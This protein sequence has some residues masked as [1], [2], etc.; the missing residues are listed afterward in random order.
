MTENNMSRNLSINAYFRGLAARHAPRLRYAGQEFHLWQS[1]LR[2]A[3]RGTLG[4]MPAR[5]P[6]NPE[7]MAEWREDGVIKQRV[8]IDVEEGLS[9]VA[10]V[11]RPEGGR[12]RL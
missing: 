3:G 12:G 11:F 7:L 1:E 10:Y 8:V 6:L 5:V 9:V 2:A 4:V